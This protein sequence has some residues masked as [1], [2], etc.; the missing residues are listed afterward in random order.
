M[1]DGDEREWCRLFGATCISDSHRTFGLEK[2]KK[3]YAVRRGERNQAGR[4]EVG[5]VNQRKKTAGSSDVETM[6]FRVQ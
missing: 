4:Q 1:R 5:S 6:K 3:I 2:W